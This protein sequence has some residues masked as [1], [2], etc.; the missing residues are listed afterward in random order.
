MS[1]V[2]LLKKIKNL[3]NES[4]DVFCLKEKFYYCYL[5]VRNYL[6]FVGKP[7]MKNDGWALTL[8]K[9]PILIWNYFIWLNNF[10][11]YDS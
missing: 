6:S 2:L 10:H 9:S 1:A 5:Y 3:W 4:S 8:F 7:F 11:L